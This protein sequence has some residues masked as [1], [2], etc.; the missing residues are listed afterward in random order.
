MNECCAFSFN[1]R[2]HVKRDNYKS[3]LQASSMTT[4]RSAL[5]YVNNYIYKLIIPD[6]TKTPDMMTSVCIF[7]S[8]CEKH[9]QNQAVIDASL[10]ANMA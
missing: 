2:V 4:T 1:Y 3:C 6:L 7:L 5:K 10:P 8:Q 9:Q